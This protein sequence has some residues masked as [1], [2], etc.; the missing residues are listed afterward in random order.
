MWK[1]T[2]IERVRYEKRNI[3]KETYDR[4]QVHLLAI[5]KRRDMKRDLHVWKRPTNMKRY[6]HIWIET[7]NRRAGSWKGKYEKRPTYMTEA[8]INKRR[9]TY[10]KKESRDRMLS[11]F[12]CPSKKVSYEKRPTCKKETNQYEDRLK[13]VKRNPCQKAKS[14]FLPSKQMR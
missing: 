3:W 1:E 10:I 6:K 8:N 13:C 2:Y 9:P 5:R 4:K 12:S 7:H 11:P 14:I